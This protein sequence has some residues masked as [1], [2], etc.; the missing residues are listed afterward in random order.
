M[1]Y[2]VTGNHAGITSEAAENSPYHHPYDGNLVTPRYEDPG[3]TGNPIT[4]LFWYPKHRAY[5]T[6]DCFTG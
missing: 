5:Q 3:G 1:I 2:V 4:L 6:S